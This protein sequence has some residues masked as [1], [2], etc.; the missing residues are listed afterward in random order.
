VVGGLRVAHHGKPTQA[1]LAELGFFFGAAMA[2]VALSPTVLVAVLCTVLVGYGSIAFVATANGV[3]QVNSDPQMR[4]RVMALYAIAFL[5]ST[6]IG[7][8]LIGWIAQAASPRVALIVGAVA[9][10]A[11][12][13]LL[14]GHGK[15][16]R[17]HHG[18]VPS[19]GAT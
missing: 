7:G 12:A 15:R 2:A 16:T 17:L 19:P 1:R 4:G 5:G 11:S 10:I 8:P 6:P 14:V 13:V 3:L 18:H 9:T